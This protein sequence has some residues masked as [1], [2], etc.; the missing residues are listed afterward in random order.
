[1][2]TVTMQRNNFTGLVAWDTNQSLAHTFMASTV[3]TGDVGGWVILERQWSPYTLDASLVLLAGSNT[4]I[5]DGV[6]LRISEEATITVNGVFDAGGP[7]FPPQDSAPVGA[8][9]PWAIQP[10]HPS[11]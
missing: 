4:T 9:W 1:M 10:V 6:S 7:P 11:N 8:G 2:K 5:Q 3:P